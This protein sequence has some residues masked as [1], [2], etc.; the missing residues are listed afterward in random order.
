MGAYFCN[1]MSLYILFDLSSLHSLLKRDDGLAVLYRSNCES[2]LTTNKNRSIFNTNGFKIFVE[3]N[4]I[5][6]D[7]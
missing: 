1:L 7:F 4:S 5:Q 6:T 2:K 3:Y